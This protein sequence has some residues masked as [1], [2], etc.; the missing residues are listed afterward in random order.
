M[1]ERIKEAAREMLDAR[2]PAEWREAVRAMA[3]VLK[4]YDIKADN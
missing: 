3:A 4:H 2:T 1:E